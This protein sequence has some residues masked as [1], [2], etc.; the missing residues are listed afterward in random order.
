VKTT[1]SRHT[2]SSLNRS[3]SLSLHFTASRHFR[4]LAAFIDRACTGCLLRTL[5]ANQ[6][7]TQ[8]QAACASFRRFI[9]FLSRNDRRDIPSE[10]VPPA[11]KLGQRRSCLNLAPSLGPLHAHQRRES[12]TGRVRPSLIV[13]VAHAFVGSPNVLRCGVFT[14]DGFSSC[15]TYRSYARDEAANA[16]DI[17]RIAP[18]PALWQVTRPPSL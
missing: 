15:Q 5:G 18:L 11:T 17:S 14:F 3:S 4:R 7:L 9:P 6:V 2:R 16:V 1:A 13:G 12:E 10:I 8:A